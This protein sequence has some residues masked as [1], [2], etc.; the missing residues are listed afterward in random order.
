[1]LNTS[2][3]SGS[4]SGAA[5]SVN[6]GGVRG[7]SHSRSTSVA[8]RKSGEQLAIQEEDED[9][10]EEVDVFSPITAGEGVEETIFAEGEM[11]SER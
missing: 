7:Q 11:P 8:G 3:P 10:I 6:S 1:M 9:D 5:A 4:G 2:S